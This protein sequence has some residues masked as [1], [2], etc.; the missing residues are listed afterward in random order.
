MNAKRKQQK[1]RKTI[2]F[3]YEIKQANKS[4]PTIRAMFE[5]TSFN[6][7]LMLLIVASVVLVMFENILSLSP[8]NAQSVSRINE[9]LTIFFVCELSLRWLIS[10]STKDFFAAFWL[11]ILAVVPL[12][13]VF[14]L[15]RVL[16]VLRILRLFRFFTI[17]DGIKKTFPF[18]KN[19]PSVNWVE[20]GLII[21]IVFFSVFFGAAGFAHFESESMGPETAFWKALFS[22]FAGE[23]ADYPESIGGKIVLLSL[24]MFSM[25]IFAMLTGTFSAI[26]LEKLKESAM[27]KN[28]DLKSLSGHMIICGFSAKTHILAKEFLLEPSFKDS[29]IVIVSE[30]VDLE[31]LKAKGLDTKRVRFLKEDFTHMNALIKAGV[32]RAS[33]AVILSEPGEHRTTQDIDARTILTA[34]TVEKLHPGIHT[35]AEIYN[36]EYAAHL[37]N[38]GVEDV[39][40]QGDF[41]GR[42]LAKISMHQGLLAFFKDLLSRE[43]GN[44]LSFIDPPKDVIGTNCAEAMTYINKELGYTLVGIKPRAKDLIVNPSSH[45]ID[46]TDEILVIHP[47]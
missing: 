42:L 26:M 24:M 17:S 25:G 4:F 5:S 7:F 6:L 15:G 13:R 47:A 2:K 23:Y 9:V 12:F 43:S 1:L 22:L 35:S 34:L 32:E 37:K 31:T 16:R 19:I 8:A 14:R 11:D 38:G 36:E 20:Y 18:L 3:N 30:N 45:T 27:Y 46:E 39:I 29:E 10:N 21:T 40:L 44:T 28:Q 41:S 33:V